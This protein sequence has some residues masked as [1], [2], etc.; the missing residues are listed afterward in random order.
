MVKSSVA[1]I[2]TIKSNRNGPA[3]VV[4][5]FGTYVNKVMVYVLYGR[6]VFYMSEVNG[7]KYM[8][9]IVSSFNAPSLLCPN[10]SCIT[11]LPSQYSVNK[12]P[13]A[14]IKKNAT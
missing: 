2:T 3:A 4:W 7:R 14:K 13:F 8:I 11:Q 5:S 9:S 6:F 12:H 10:S 1:Q